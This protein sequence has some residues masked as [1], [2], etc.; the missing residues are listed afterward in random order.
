MRV[1]TTVD[2]LTGRNQTGQ[3]ASVH[4][5]A[6]MKSRLGAAAYHIKATS[7]D[8]AQGMPAADILTFVGRA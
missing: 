2:G 6:A 3:G 4:H 7:G 5:T 1:A 8:T